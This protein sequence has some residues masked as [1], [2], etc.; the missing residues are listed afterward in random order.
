MV[1]ALPGDIHSQT[2]LQV[3]LQTTALRVMLVDTVLKEALTHSAVATVPQGDTLTA[4]QQLDLQKLIARCVMLGGMEEE[5][6]KAVSAL[7]DVL[8]GG[9]RWQARRRDLHQSTALRA[10]LDASPRCLVQR[11]QLIVLVASLANMLIQLV[12]MTQRIVSIVLQAS[13]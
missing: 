11:Q 7:V 4:P 5:A 12:V 13:I 6:V 3:L 8:L 9:T 10:V 1:H 2:R